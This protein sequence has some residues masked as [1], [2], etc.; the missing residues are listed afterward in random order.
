[1]TKILLEVYTRLIQLSP[2]PAAAPQVLLKA[3]GLQTSGSE[4]STIM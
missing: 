3:L 1:M 2:K 4:A